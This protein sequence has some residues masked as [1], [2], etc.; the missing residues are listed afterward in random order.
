MAD[1]FCGLPRFVKTIKDPMEFIGGVTRT[2]QDSHAFKSV[3]LEPL[4]YTK[5][6]KNGKW[7]CV[8]D[9]DNIEVDGTLKV[10]AKKNFIERFFVEREPKRDARF[11]PKRHGP[12]G[13]AQQEHHKR[14]SGGEVLKIDSGA[15]RGK[16]IGC[17]LFLLI[18]IVIVIL[19]S[20]GIIS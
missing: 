8:L 19:F 13:P 9:G 20:L 12:M 1:N 11:L 16:I 3:T 6:S 2:M 7:I 14:I 15:I 18:A 10:V 17:C 5:T 4:G